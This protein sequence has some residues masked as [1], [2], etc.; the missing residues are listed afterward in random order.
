MASGTADLQRDLGGAIMQSIFGALL[1]AGYAAAFTTAI[2]AAP[3]KQQITTSVQ[4][5]LIKSFASAAD[6]A[7]QYPQYAS[8]INAA[9]KASFLKGDQWA[10]TAGIIAILAGLALVFFMF[11]GKQQELDL[12]ARY[13]GQ[14]A[15][16]QAVSSPPQG[17]APQL[18]RPPRPG[19]AE[20]RAGPNSGPGRTTGR[21][22][23]PGQTAGI[24]WPPGLTRITGTH[25]DYGDSPR[26][27]SSRDRSRA[28]TREDTPSL[29]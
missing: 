29:R 16:E 19:R 24:S 2:A 13:H 21:A 17:R 12:L 6:A 5:E 23:Q 11:P 28:L 8:Q 1:A 14:A 18:I 9:A 20:Q 26:R 22:E 27:P 15:S 3:N 25:V 4:N 7:K 10:Y